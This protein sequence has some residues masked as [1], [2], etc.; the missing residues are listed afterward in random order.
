[1]ALGARI[2]RFANAHFIQVTDG[3]PRDESD[4][5]RYGFP[6]WV[7]YRDARSREIA[8]MLHLAGLALMTR[9]CL[10]I[11]DQQPTLQLSQLAR[12][13]AQRIQ[14]LRP[15]VILTHPY[16]GGHPDHDACAFAVHHACSLAR[17]PA[18][19]RPIVVE[20]AFYH[21]G[22]NVI[23]TETFLPPPAPVPEIVRPLSPREQSRKRERMDCFVTQRT[24]LSQFPCEQ[25]RF[26]VAPPY[27][28]T[29]P[30]HPGPALYDNFPWGMTSSRF[31]RLAARARGD[32]RQQANG[33]SR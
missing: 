25:E 4:S 22:P 13:I 2:G 30:A 8:A 7:E 29:R 16:E 18:D 14:D 10:N 12:Q 28:F 23:E 32:L 19:Q 9:E 31:C 15:A 11:P 27:D 3:A 1:M 26:R 17:L 6:S 20:A 24:T 21:A 5:R 33:A